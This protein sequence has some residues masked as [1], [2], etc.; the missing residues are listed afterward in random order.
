MIALLRFFLIVFL[1]FTLF[2][3]EKDSLGQGFPKGILT[4]K[5][6]RPKDCALPACSEERFIVA[7]AN[8]VE[9]IILETS[10]PG[11]YLFHYNFTFDSYITFRICN[12]P[13][14]YHIDGLRVRYGGF[15]LD[16]CGVYLASWPEEETYILRLTNIKRI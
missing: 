12:L 13:D 7:E 1:S 8:N 15:L 4:Y 6:S 5:D 11:Q 3:C 14:E 10:N 9:G 16:P 2:S